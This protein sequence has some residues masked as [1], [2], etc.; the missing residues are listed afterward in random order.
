MMV[1]VLLI[2]GD[3]DGKIEE[4]EYKRDGVII[5]YNPI[6]LSSHSPEREMRSPYRYTMDAMIIDG[7]YY[8]YASCKSIDV[9]EIEPLIKTSYLKPM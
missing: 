5:H 8:A 3:H 6:V 7:Q 9:S 2:G 1:Q 4:H